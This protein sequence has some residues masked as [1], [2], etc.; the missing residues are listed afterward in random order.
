TTQP[1]ATLFAT[2]AGAIATPFAS[3][4]TLT[5]RCLPGKRPLGPRAGAANVTAT[6]ATGFWCASV[7]VTASRIGKRV[8]TEIDSVAAAPGV[9]A[10]ALPA[11]LRRAKL[12][13]GA[14]PLV[15]AEAAN[16][17]AVVFAGSAGE[18]AMPAA[19]VVA[20]AWVE[21]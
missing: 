8:P 16:E 4:S 5:S 2:S 1:P 11:R 7:T 15:A 9:I 6:P 3:V 18:V 17:P 19:V 21:P 10:A 12:T 13:T 20:V 14:S